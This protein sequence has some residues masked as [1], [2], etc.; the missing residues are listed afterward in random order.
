MVE[1]T[2]AANSFVICV[3]ENDEDMFQLPYIL[4]RNRKVRDK[5]KARHPQQKNAEKYDEGDGYRFL[6]PFR[7]SVAVC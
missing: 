1:R 7:R 5:K 4:Q 3:R 6:P 2:R